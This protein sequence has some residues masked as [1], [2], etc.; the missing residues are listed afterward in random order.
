MM[1]NRAIGR[2]AAV[3]AVLTTLT[4]SAGA[5]QA[6]PPLGCMD[7]AIRTQAQTIKEH[8]QKQGFDLYRDAMFTMERDQQVPVILTLQRGQ[9]YEI[10]FVA[11][12]AFKSMKLNIFDGQDERVKELEGV[13]NRDQP[14]YLI[15]SFTPTK[16]DNYLIMSE[17][18]TKLRQMCGSFFVLKA[19]PKKAGN[20]VIHYSGGP[21]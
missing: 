7:G 4:F 1:M 2:M 12:P 21:G 6:A 10:I 8:Y 16:T 15:F 3:A 13:R 18:N 9:I 17:Q 14:N 11:H 20:E 5:Q 19:D